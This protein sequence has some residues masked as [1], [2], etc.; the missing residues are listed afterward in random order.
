MSRRHQNF[1]RRIA[2]P[3]A[4]KFR[5]LRVLRHVPTVPVQPFSSRPA[6]YPRKTSIDNAGRPSHGPSSAPRLSQAV[7]N[8]R[9]TFRN[10]NI[11]KASLIADKNAELAPVSVFA[12]SGPDMKFEWPL[13]DQREQAIGRTNSE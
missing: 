1:P 9:Q 2:S 8:S 3:R 12:A 13:I 7:P 10:Q 5:R 11:S 6:A 4:P